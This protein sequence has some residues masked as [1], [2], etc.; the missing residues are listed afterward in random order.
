MAPVGGFG[1]CDD[2]FMVGALFGPHVDDGFPFGGASGW[3]FEFGREVHQWTP[4]Q[5][6]DHIRPFE[7]LGAAER[8]Q[9]PHGVRPFSRA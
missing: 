6:G 8:H 3:V 4:F 2:G 5:G 1:G 9:N 7:V